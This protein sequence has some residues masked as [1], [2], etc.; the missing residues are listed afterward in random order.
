MSE[1]LK[2]RK[3]LFGKKKILSYMDDM[4]EGAALTLIKE[5][6]PVRIHHGRWSAHVDNLEAWVQVWTKVSYAGQELPEDSE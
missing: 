1:S 6:L 2:T 3:M 4:G 5:G